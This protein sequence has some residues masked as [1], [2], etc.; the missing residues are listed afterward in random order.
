MSSENLSLWTKLQIVLGMGGA[1]HL[2]RVY[3]NIPK[4]FLTFQEAELRTQVALGF[5]IYFL[6]TQLLRLFSR[7]FFSADPLSVSIGM[8]FIS[9]IIILMYRELGN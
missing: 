1:Y 6:A 4:D 2:Y 3:P 5:F 7:L 9:F 8:I